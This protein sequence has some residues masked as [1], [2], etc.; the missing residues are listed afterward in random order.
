MKTKLKL[1]L[2]LFILGFLGVLTLLTATLPLPLNN[3]PEQLA[4]LPPFII[5]LLILINPTI[6]LL[7]A[8]TVGTVLY[9]KVNLTVPTISSLLR[10]KHPQTSFIQQLKYGVSL[11]L[12]AGIFIMLIAFIFKQVIPEEFKI[13]ENKIEFTLLARFGY[14]GIVEELLLRFG[15][16]TLV[17]WITSKLTRRLNDITYWIGII[18]PAILFAV[19]HFPIV[20]ASVSHPSFLLLTYIL[21]DNF[22]GGLI[23]GWLYWKKGLEAA[24]I[25]HIFTHVAMV[26]IGLFL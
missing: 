9:D 11:G 25:A 24:C 10:I 18:L 3:L 5:K 15:F 16:M 12:L 2:A 23:F 6:L 17:V 22:I 13:L 8:V 14:G 4:Q 26:S 20:F 19:A 7:I 21:I 1:G